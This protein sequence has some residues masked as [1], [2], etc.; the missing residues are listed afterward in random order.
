MTLK[1]ASSYL[2]ISFFG[3][4]T[5]VKLETGDETIVEQHHQE[6]TNIN[7]IVARYQRSGE[8]PPAPEARYMDVSN[9]GDLMD[10]K[11][12]IAETSEN[13]EKLPDY[14]KEKLPLADIE[15]VSNE[16]LQELF[17]GYIQ[18]QNGQPAKEDSQTESKATEQTKETP[19]KGQPS[20]D[21]IDS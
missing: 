12:R 3:V 13:Y 10:V 8:M 20:P 21:K 1:K 7:K 18:N 5:P 4:R 16:T 6:T 11:L 9:I 15:N 17:D 2:P 19:G 14:I